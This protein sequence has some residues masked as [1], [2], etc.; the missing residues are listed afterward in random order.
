MAD[1]EKRNI[2]GTTRF[3][4]FS[5]WTN[6]VNGVSRLIR[7]AR[8]LQ[9][10]RNKEER[11]DEESV[12]EA[13]RCAQML[14]IRS[15]QSESFKDEIHCSK[16][17][18]ILSKSSQLRS[19]NPI[20]DPEGILRVGGR[21]HYVDSSY[22]ER[23]PAI[24]PSKH[25]IS[26][27]IVENLHEEVKHQGRHFTHG[28]VRGKGFWIVGEKRL[29]NRV[30][31]ECFTCRRLRGKFQQQKMADLPPERVHPSPPFTNIGIDVFGPWY[32]VARRTRGGHASSK[33]WAVLFTCLAT[34]AV[35]I[36]PI[37]S[38]DTSSFINALRRFMAIRGP[39][40]LIRSDRGTNFVG[41]RNEFEAALK[42]MDRNI[43]ES[44]L[45]SQGCT[46][47]FNPPHA[48]HMG[49]AWE[50]MIGV[51]RRILD[52]VLLTSQIT[53]LTHEVLST[54]L[55]K[56]RRSSITDHS[57]RFPTTLRLRKY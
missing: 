17:K 20:I 13:K 52:S 11:D 56:S 23:H 42:E 50:R 26:R 18:K 30:I 9:R 14:I 5:R 29:I 3:L 1:P 57:Y 40:R 37:E 7:L 6:L 41:A 33:R 32:V 55:A 53:H 38:M 49:G 54:F 51:C 24:L 46:W 8:R 34:R 25:H 10:H 27:L 35:H 21:L 2:L 39:V 43:I 15:V 16:N 44:Y 36:E 28:M 22:E 31:H 4:R 48:S 12:V 47:E 19:L 45:T